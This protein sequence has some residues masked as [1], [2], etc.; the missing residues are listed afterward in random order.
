MKC[1][2]FSSVPFVVSQAELVKMTATMPY[3]VVGNKV[4]VDH[5]VSTYGM[6]KAAH[7]VTIAFA[8]SF[9]ALLNQEHNS[10]NAKNKD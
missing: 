2:T 1:Y 9:Y 8:E 4:N 3:D 10:Y 7:Y 5:A 6:E